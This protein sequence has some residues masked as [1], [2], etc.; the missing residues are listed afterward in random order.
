M[1]YRAVTYISWAFVMGRWIRL[2]LSIT[3]EL[4]RAVLRW[5]VHDAW[6]GFRYS[7]RGI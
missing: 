2:R 6:L 5:I 3:D 1:P 7:Y 4:D